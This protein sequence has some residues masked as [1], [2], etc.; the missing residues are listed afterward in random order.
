MSTSPRLILASASPRRRELLAELGMPFTVV[1]AEVTEHEDPTTNPRI[2][3]AHNAALKADWVAARQPEAW[4]LGADTTVC[5]GDIV[6]NKPRDLAEARAMLRRL[7]GRT[8]T[9]FTGLALR[10][11]ASGFNCDA[12]AASEV[13]FH[14]LTDAVIADYLAKVHVL[15]KAGGYGIQEH[16]EMLVA[17]QTGSFSNIMGL[18][19]E[20]TKQILTNAGLLR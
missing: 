19:L 12:V 2:M 7:S 17:V 20:A 8:H 16:G 3:V 11:G 9:V 14:E 10:Q 6:L 13:T 1:V 18:P 5:I 15:D 4:V